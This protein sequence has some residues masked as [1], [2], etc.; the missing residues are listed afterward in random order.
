VP[1]RLV[2]SQ[3]AQAG[4][5]WFKVSSHGC[6]I[7]RYGALHVMQRVHGPKRRAQ[8]QPAAI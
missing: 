6:W 7:R 2:G 5:C 3:S 1:R 4:E 8:L